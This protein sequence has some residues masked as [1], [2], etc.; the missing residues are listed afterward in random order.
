MV[1]DDRSYLHFIYTM[2]MSSGEN[3]ML[4]NKTSPHAQPSMALVPFAQDLAVSAPDMEQPVTTM[5]AQ[6]RAFPMLHFHHHECKEVQVDPEVWVVVTRLAV[7]HGKI[8]SF[9]HK[10]THQLEGVGQ[11]R[12]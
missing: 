8:F 6:A 4:E 11:Q 3:H 7:Q 9:L 1:T 12:A 2:I 5:G 10:R